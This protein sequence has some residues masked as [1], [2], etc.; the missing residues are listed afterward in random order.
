M[1]IILCFVGVGV[2]V[3]VSG[4][5]GVIVIGEIIICWVC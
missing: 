3:G 5:I 2:F 4:L 1:I